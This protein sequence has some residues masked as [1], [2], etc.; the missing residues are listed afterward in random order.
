MTP[1]KATM[2]DISGGKRDRGSDNT[3]KPVTTP[4]TRDSK[5]SCW[6]TDGINGAKNGGKTIE[7]GIVT[8]EQINA[9]DDHLDA[10]DVI[11]IINHID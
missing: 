4:N 5:L 1:E 3:D 8:G 9:N 11:T 10:P 2:A 6:D 7:N